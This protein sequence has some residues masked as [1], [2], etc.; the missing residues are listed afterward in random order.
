MNRSNKNNVNPHSH[1][2]DAG[3][4]STLNVKS[5]RKCPIRLKP[6]LQ[7]QSYDIST[8]T[9]KPKAVANSNLKHWSLTTRISSFK[10]TSKLINQKNFAEKALKMSLK[11]WDNQYSPKGMSHLTFKGKTYSI[12]INT[13]THYS[14]LPS[15]YYT[16]PIPH[17]H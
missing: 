10:S 16:I 4:K 11:G 5:R 7:T 14:F 17:C 9:L 2:I 3:P 6:N 15:M 1:D 13:T 12:N 8:M